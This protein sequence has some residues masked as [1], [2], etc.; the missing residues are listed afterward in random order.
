MRV[1]M[2]CPTPPPGVGWGFAKFRVSKEPPLGPNLEAKDAPLGGRVI[3]KPV[4]SNGKSPTPGDGEFW[5]TRADTPPYPGRGVGHFID[6][7][8]TDTLNKMASFCSPKMHVFSL[9]TRFW[10]CLI[11]IQQA[12]ALLPLREYTVVLND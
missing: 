9:N 8:I 12:G 5:Q 1:S 7:R 6:T 2:K 11:L 4:Y 3:S 10:Q